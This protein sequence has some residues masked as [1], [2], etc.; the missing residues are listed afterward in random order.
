[1]YLAIGYL[2]VSCWPHLNVHISTP[3]EDWQTLLYVG[4][5]SHL[6]LEIAAVVLAYCAFSIFMSWRSGKLVEAVRAQGEAVPPETA[7]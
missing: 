2:M 5:L 3:I 7:R 1:M 6:P 4:F